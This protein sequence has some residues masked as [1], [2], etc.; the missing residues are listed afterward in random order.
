[1]ATNSSIQ[2]DALLVNAISSSAESVMRTMAQTE[3]KLKEVAASPTYKPTGDIS[4]IIGIMGESG[5]GMLSL[6]FPMSLANLLVSRLLGV[7]VGKINSDDRCDAIGELANMI[8][9]KAKIG[10]MR[11]GSAPYKLSLPTVI[12]GAQ[13]EVSSGP[14][15]IPYLILTFECENEI[16]TMQ[17]SFKSNPG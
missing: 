15:G 9:G 13:H 6:S 17:V 16:F 8:S 1:M 2:L 12:M 7:P 5:E 3:V 10:L 14:R 4:A 11:E